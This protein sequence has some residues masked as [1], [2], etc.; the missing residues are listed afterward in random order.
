MSETPSALAAAARSR[1][2]RLGFD[3]IGIQT[4]DL[5]NCVNWYEAFLGCRRAWSLDQF[6]ELTHSRLPGIRSLTEIVVGDLRLHVFER[7]GRMPDPAESATQY[8]HLCLRVEDPD[9][10][11]RFRQLWVELFASG[12]Y[13]YARDDQPTE[14]VIDADGVQSFYAHDVNGLEL[15]FTYLPP[16]RP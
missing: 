2:P 7:P 10:L 11:T 5:D 12:Q 13:T 16:G 1:H 14:I 8:Q 4:N 15:E 9:D 6:S 3:H